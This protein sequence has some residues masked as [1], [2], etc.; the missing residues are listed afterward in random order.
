MQVLETLTFKTEAPGVRGSDRSEY[1][2][3]CSRKQ[4]SLC[5]L[6]IMD[7]KIVAQEKLC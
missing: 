1:R 7:I 4:L 5:V 2:T 6:S 3:L